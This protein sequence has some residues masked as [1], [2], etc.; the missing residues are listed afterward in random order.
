MLRLQTRV[1]RRQRKSWPKLYLY[2]LSSLGV[3][4]RQLA[5]INMYRRRQR[6]WLG[7]DNIPCPRGSLE[8][9]GL[10]GRSGIVNVFVVPLVMAIGFPK[11]RSL[12]RLLDWQHGLMGLDGKQHRLGNRVQIELG[13]MLRV[14][15]RHTLRRQTVIHQQI[16]LQNVT[17][18]S[19]VIS[20]QRRP[21]VTW[22]GV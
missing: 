17:V 3:K 5:L 1:E 16:L 14:E 11:R 10:Q 6:A 9:E 21:D 4:R 15:W 22:L 20:G 7:G 19:D 2:S 8:M 18:L 12:V 13:R